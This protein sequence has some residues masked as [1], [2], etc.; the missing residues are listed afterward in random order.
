MSLGLRAPERWWLGPLGQAFWGSFPPPAPSDFQ[1]AQDKQS[2][3][4]CYLSAAF[5]IL[6]EIKGGGAR[7]ER[8]AYHWICLS[9]HMYTLA[10]LRTG[11]QA[12]PTAAF[13]KCPKIH[14]KGSK[15]FPSKAFPLLL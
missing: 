10:F 12:N 2:F 6:P 13:L 5:L 9:S 11:G 3:R 7:E 1:Q 4:I 14:L 15:D 8:K